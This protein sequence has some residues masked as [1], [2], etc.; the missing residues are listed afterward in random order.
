MY[1]VLEKSLHSLFIKMLNNLTGKGV[2]VHALLLCETFMNQ[3]NINESDIPGYD[4]YVT[5]RQNKGKVG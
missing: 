4:K 5:F 2:N 1:T 3:L